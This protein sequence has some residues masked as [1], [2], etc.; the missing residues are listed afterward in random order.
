MSLT[1]TISGSGRKAWLNRRSASHVAE[2]PIDSLGRNFTL[3][4]ILRN[5]V[6]VEHHSKGSGA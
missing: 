2:T 4:K 1:I 3:W 5:R 6:A